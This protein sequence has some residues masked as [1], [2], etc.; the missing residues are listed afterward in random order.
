MD[1]ESLTLALSVDEKIKLHREYKDY[2][3]SGYLGDNSFL[4][5][6]TEKTMVEAKIY[7]YML[8]IIAQQIMFK[9]YQQSF[10]ILYI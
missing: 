1:I 2:E 8:P 7:H 4:R 3:K 6:L 9:I 5:E 10:V